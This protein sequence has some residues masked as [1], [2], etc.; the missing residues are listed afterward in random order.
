MFETTVPPTTAGEAGPRRDALGA[1]SQWQGALA[2]AIADGSGLD[3]AA[4]VDTIRALEQLVCT[5]TA[6]QA[7]LSAELDASQRTE[8]AAAGVPAARRGVGVAAQ[9][10]L[11][12]R[13]SHHRGQRHLGLARIVTT[14]LPH[15]WEAWRSGSITEWTATLVARETACL[16]RDDRAAVDALVASDPA[17]LEAMGVREVVATCQREA[18]RLD[19]AAVLARR[20]RAERDRHVT[21]RPAPD[22]MTWLT[23]LLPV[24]DGVAVHAALARAAES[25]R[26]RGDGASKGQV[27]ADTLV[28]AVLSAAAQRDRAATQWHPDPTDDV[29]AAPA[30]GLAL[31]L[32]MSDLALFGTSEEPGHLEGYGPIPAE[33]ARELVAGACSRDEKVWLRRLYTS[34]ATGELLSM[35]ARGRLFP[36]GLAR[37][38][39]L[40]DQTCRTPWCD[41]AIRDTDHAQEHHAGGP[42]SSDNGQGL[43]EACNHAKQAPGWRARPSPSPGRHHIDTTTPTGRTY[44]SRPPVVVTIREVPYRIDYALTG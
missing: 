12:R 43:C 25:A 37:F 27:M 28:S 20:R 39:R 22:T 10:A 9:V 7:R 42:T 3:P 32:V 26:A 13:E 23:A 29:S 40:R 24:K 34:P 38:V 17:R 19:P 5:A 4:L 2:S 14:E 15:T 6:A 36:T 21:L 41:A 31:H 16:S 44:R 1:V 18:A 30:G 33:L 8:Q 35:D 11:A